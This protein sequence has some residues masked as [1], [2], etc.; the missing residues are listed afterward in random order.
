MSDILYFVCE[1]VCAVLEAAR[2][3]LVI[4][5]M[6]VALFMHFILGII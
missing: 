2:H 1:I 6:L 5:M 4:V 3:P